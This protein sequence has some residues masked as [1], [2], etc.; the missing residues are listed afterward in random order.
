MR[1]VPTIYITKLDIWLIFKENQSNWTGFIKTKGVLLRLY[2][3]NC[4][5]I[6]VA[7]ILY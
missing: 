6:A 7:A 2:T 1:I 3:L 5:T 4:Q